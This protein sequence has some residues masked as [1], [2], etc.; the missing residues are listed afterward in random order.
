M[1][2]S[3]GFQHGGVTAKHSDGAMKG[4][5]M[6]NSASDYPEVSNGQYCAVVVGRHKGKSGIVQDRNIS[7][8][9]H[10]TITVMQDDGVRFKTLA[11]SVNVLNN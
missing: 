9:G 5:A 4:L 10:V 11:K 8:S 6:A 2:C 3:N 1:N 7:K